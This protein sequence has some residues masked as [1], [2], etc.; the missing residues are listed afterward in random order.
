MS[1]DSVFFSD[2]FALRFGTLVNARELYDSM[3]FAICD[4]CMYASMRY[5]NKY[6]GW[7]RMK[8]VKQEY[9]L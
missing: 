1:V 5:T 8:G 6:S 4:S 9:Q 7:R 2:T 3:I